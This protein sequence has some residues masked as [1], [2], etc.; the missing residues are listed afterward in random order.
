MA[1]LKRSAYSSCKLFCVSAC[2]LIYSALL[3]VLF[4][5][6]HVEV[7]VEIHNPI[8]AAHLSAMAQVQYAHSQTLVRCLS[9]PRLPLPLLL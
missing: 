8:M 7:P 4:A 1:V 5:V 2:T 9:C 6:E 3:V